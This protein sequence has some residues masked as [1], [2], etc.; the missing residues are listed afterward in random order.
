M[1]PKL[2]TSSHLLIEKDGKQYKATVGTLC[3]IYGRAEGGVVNSLKIEPPANDYG[4]LFH[5]KGETADEFADP[6][7]FYFYKNQSGVLDAI[8]Y[9]GAI[10]NDANI[11]NLGYLNSRLKELEQRIEALGG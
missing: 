11:I 3:N 2:D 4:R 9:N 8:N 6:Q 1:S 5:I 7:F 10:R